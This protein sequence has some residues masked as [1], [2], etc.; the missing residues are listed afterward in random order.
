MPKTSIE[1]ILSKVFAGPHWR[2]S[3]WWP[4]DSWSSKQ[5]SLLR[6]L[7][8]AHDQRLD[9][10]PLVVNLAEEHRGRYRKRLRHLSRRL[11]EGTPLVDALEQTPDA[12]SDAQVLS[13]RFANQTGIL[14][15]TYQRL[16]KERDD[17]SRRTQSSLR[18]LLVYSIGMTLILGLVLTFLMVKVTP[19]FE[20]M[21]EEFGAELPL[22]FQWATAVSRQFANLWFLWIFLAVAVAWLCWS[23]PSR[24]FFRRTSL[25]S[26]IRGSQMRSAEFLRLMAGVVEAGRPIPSALSTLARHHFDKNFRQRLMFARIESE[27]RSDVWN[28]LAETHLLTSVETTVLENASSNQSRAWMMR[29]LADCKEE[30]ILR[31]GVVVASFARPLVVLC[32]ATIVLFVCVAW[33]GALSHLVNSL[34]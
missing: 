19:I 28:I 32:F 31:R 24:R 11:A 2:L 21:H 18:Q 12:L 6:L 23:L 10:V 5:H 29:R 30:K 14:K 15:T 22:V 27:H 1:A 8:V 4:S 13:L 25:G 26:W 3:P 20:K 33:F 16:G 17:S 9:L 34:A 7:S